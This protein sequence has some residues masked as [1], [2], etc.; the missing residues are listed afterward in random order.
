MSVATPSKIPI[1]EKIAVIEITFSL[2]FDF[3][4]LKVIKNFNFII[5]IFI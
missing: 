5:L 2:F 3:K 1:K 4:Y